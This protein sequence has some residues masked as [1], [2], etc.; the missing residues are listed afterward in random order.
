MHLDWSFP[1]Q[2][3][4][5]GSARSLKVLVKCDEPCSYEVPCDDFFT[6]ATM[7]VAVAV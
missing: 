3:G 1:I 5:L 6:G 7:H 2:S 4:Y